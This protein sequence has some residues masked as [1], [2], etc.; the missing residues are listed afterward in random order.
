GGTHASPP[1]GGEV[2][3]GPGGE[4][5]PAAGG[6]LSAPFF[7]HLCAARFCPSGTPSLPMLP[8]CGIPGRCRRLDV[9]G[10][11]SGRGRNRLRL[12]PFGG[13]ASRCNA[14]V[15]RVLA[16]V[17]ARRGRRRR[18]VSA[19]VLPCPIRRIVAGSTATTSV[20]GTPPVHGSPS[21]E[22][23]PGGARRTRVRSWPASIPRPGSESM[24]C[25]GGG[26]SDAV[27]LGGAVPPGR[28]PVEPLSPAAGSFPGL[29][30]CWT[31]TGFGPRCPGGC[32]ACGS[33]H[34]RIR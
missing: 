2:R 22:S 24:T 6:A 8:R 18:R 10:G 14:D 11:R 31:R 3:Q 25:E 16:R 4:A 17:I 32:G 7:L 12:Q 21:L 29:E 1:S 20:L 33:R 13:N 9:G 28:C 23:R 26:R 30:L 15:T 27:V 34:G 5:V 19:D